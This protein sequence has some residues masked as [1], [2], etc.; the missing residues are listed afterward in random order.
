MRRQIQINAKVFA[1]EEN[2]TNAIEEIAFV[3][4]D[5][6]STDDLHRVFMC[7]THF[8][9]YDI[10]SIESQKCNFCDICE[11]CEIKA[12]TAN[13]NALEEELTDM[14]VDNAAL[15]TKNAELEKKLDDFNTSCFSAG[16]S[17]NPCPAPAPI[18]KLGPRKDLWPDTIKQID[19]YTPPGD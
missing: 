8:L 1:V 11:Q 5:E 16:K 4:D 3:L 9:G 2:T 18:P 6:A 10:E 12:D 19:W 7:L 13:L 17:C 15:R 14:K